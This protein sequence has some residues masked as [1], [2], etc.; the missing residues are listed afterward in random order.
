[1]KKVVY[2]VKSQLHLYP[3]CISQIRMLKKESINVQV[4][5]GSCSNEVIDL[6]NNEGIECISLGEKRG[7][8]PGKLD[9]I[10]NWSAFGK[11][12]KKRMNSYQNLSDTLFWFG[13]A[14]S[15]IPLVGKLKGISYALTSLELPDDDTFKRI[16]FGKLASKAMFIVSCE[17]TRAYIMRYWYGLKRLPYIM[18]NKPYDFDQRRRKQPSIKASER[19]INSIKDKKFII[20]QGIIKS[21]EYMIEMVRA[22]KDSNMDYYFVLMGQDPENIYSDVRKEY[23]RTIF[24]ENIPAPFHLEVTSYA[25]IGFVF[26]DENS[27][28]NRAFCAPNKIYEYSGLGIPS[29]GNMVPGLVNTIGASKAGVCCEMKKESISNAIRMI[30]MNYDEYSKNAYKFYDS[31]DNENLMKKIIQ[32]NIILP[33]I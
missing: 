13:T 22:I 9:K 32:E 10:N 2:I 33:T 24:I 14:E 15:A 3:P 28:L 29:I 20:Y 16:M 4:W 17:T 31:V 11:T 7:I 23:E 12:V 25:E 21:K 30:S 1:M 18:P 6:L 5:Y 19:A 27:S 26:Y 8:L